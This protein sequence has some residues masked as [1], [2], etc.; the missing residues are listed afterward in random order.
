MPR[1][2]NVSN[3][4]KAASKPRRSTRRSAARG[5]EIPDVY[6]E[7]LV[8]A[9][10]NNP[11]DFAPDPRPA[12]RRKVN[13]TPTPEPAPEPTPEPALPTPP[14]A[15]LEEAIATATSLPPQQQVI[16]NNDYDDSDDS[17]IEFEDVEIDRG[18]SDVDTPEPNHLESKSL[19]INLAP[20]TTTQPKTAIR[21]RPVT[22]A[23]RDFRLDVHK[24]HVLCLIVHAAVRN[25]WCDDEI[26]QKTLK[27][28]VSRKI[29]SQL[30]LDESYSQTKRK[31]SFDQAIEQICQIWNQHWKVSA[32]GMRRAYWRENL[33]ITK[34]I[35]NA[36]DPTDL[37]DFKRAAKDCS[38]SRD[39]GAQH[40]CALL[41]SVAVEARLV[42]SLQALPFSRVAKG[43]TP[44]KPQPSYIQAGD[45]NFGTISSAKKKQ[46]KIVESLFPIFW[47]E[48]FNPAITQ[49]IPLDPIVRNTINKPRTGFEPPASDTLNAMSYVVAFEDDGA[50]KDV[51]RRY[52]AAYNAKTLKTR[53][54]ST[55]HGEEWWG[56]VMQFFERMLPE[57]RDEVE[58]VALQRRIATE[59]M[60]KGVQDFK[61]HPVYVLERHLKVN[62]VIEPRR[63]AGKFTVGSGKNAKVESVY[64]RQDVHLCRSADAWYRRGRDVR[65]GEQPLK[66]VIARNKH[67]GSAQIDDEADGGIESDGVALYA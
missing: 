17:D 62:E 23:E 50:A 35:E 8:E 57:S 4:A 22:K 61:G 7:M 2:K 25:K 63:E 66:R 47:V 41:R 49:W 65:A 30:H 67:T 19:Q 52:V 59:G 14:A 28:L 46:K 3:D 39:L 60:P 18:E 33:D 29:I 10:N 31:V 34:E 24:W 44:Q 38:G 26:V 37:S 6:S 36:E 21:R 1:K 42:C 27:P 48:V 54:E 16:F 53:V 64:R 43:E 5:D 56:K 40:F 20:Q 32:R 9:Y 51:T 55:K 15:Y 11:E 12:K 45:Q 13:R 58:D